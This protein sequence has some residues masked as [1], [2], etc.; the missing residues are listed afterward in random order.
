MAAV[1]KAGSSPKLG[2]R[3]SA[4]RGAGLGPVLCWAI[5]F[6]DIGTSV[7]YTPGILFG[8]VGNHA[9]LFVGLTLIV[10]VLLTIKYSEVSIRYPQGGGVVTVGADAA[11]NFVGL[12]GGLL[13]LVDYFLT[14]ALSAL[15]GL[16][17]LTVIAPDLKGTV[18]ALTVTALILIA[19]LNLMG[20]SAN[21]RITAVV[22]AIAISSQLAVI[23]AV[24]VHVGIGGALAAIP[25]AVSGPRISSVGLVTG[26]AGAFLAFSGLESIS[27]LAPT[28]APP[29]RRTA[30]R[31][32]LLVVMTVAITSPLLTLWS[33][34]LLNP[35]GDD[36]NQLISLLGGFAAGPLLQF[37]VAASAALL[38][39]FASNTAII[40]SYH[41]FLALSRM[42]FLP[43]ALQTRNRWRNTPHWAIL[44]ATTIPVVVILIS[45]GDVGILGD[46]Y[47][48]GLLGAFS[49]TCVSLDIFRWRERASHRRHGHT[50]RTAGS[51]GTS[52]PTFVIGV[53]TSLL[54]VTA[55]TTNLVAKPLATLFGGVVTTVGLAV[56]GATYYVRKRRGLPGP[57]PI[58]HRLAQAWLKS[59]RLRHP[60]LVVLSGTVKQIEALVHAGI[61]AAAQTPLIFAY[62]GPDPTHG[63]RTRILEIVD[64]YLEDENAH[65]AFTAARRVIPAARRREVHAVYASDNDRGAALTE[66][67]DR[68]N[69]KEII[70][71]SEDKETL[72][73]LGK[74][75][76]RRMQRDG[77]AMMR[78][79]RLVRVA[80]A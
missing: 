50:H 72:H 49:V 19:V 2:R 40:G 4:Q 46:M 58:A 25:K 10:F 6:A 39:V 29:N 64:P 17:Y 34:T 60:V 37:E 43:A 52:L 61:D 21:A 41:V 36:P 78:V 45:N 44:T 53:I 28:M 12:I 76:R 69:P 33:T 27:Q 66:M 1:D 14:A 38:L 22:A 8:R 24:L 16:I 55:W 18:V 30:P 63:R 67:L 59:P 26:Y 20:I 75:S 13:I 31:A 23:I 51:V 9:A 15:S 47:S 32:M 42:R 3:G 68:L 7:Y 74:G 5:V 11:N 65:L 57:V 77:V 48:F 62:L 35:K 56:A 73:A 80:H 71:L 79:A 54:V 70:A